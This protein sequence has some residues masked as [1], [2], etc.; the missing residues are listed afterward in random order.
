MF[1]NKKILEEKKEITLVNRI[2]DLIKL[3]T[4]GVL[5]QELH[6]HSRFNYPFHKE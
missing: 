3:D 4:T 6:T 1:W 2:I 5:I